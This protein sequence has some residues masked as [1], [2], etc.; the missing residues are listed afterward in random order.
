M[1]KLGRRSLLRGGG[2]ALLGSGWGNAQRTAELQLYPRNGR[3]ATRY[4][5]ERDAAGYRAIRCR[6][7]GDL[8]RVYAVPGSGR[9]APLEKFYT[10]QLASWRTFN[11]DALNQAGK[12]DYLLLDE[13]LPRPEQSSSPRKHGGRRRSRRRSLPGSHHWAGGGTAADGHHRPAEDRRGFW[14]K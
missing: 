14:R 9:R 4:G 8:N 11:F 12:I 10:E 3:D 2:L 5:T 1:T 7:C 6:V 13:R